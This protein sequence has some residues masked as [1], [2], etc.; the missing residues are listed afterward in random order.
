MQKS[1]RLM[2]LRL[3]IAIR[4]IVGK[5]GLAIIEA[6]LAGRRAKLISF[7]HKPLITVSGHFLL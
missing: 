5:S 2:N 1:L 7:L 3:D 4:D 6:I